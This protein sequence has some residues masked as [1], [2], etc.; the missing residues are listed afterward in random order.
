MKKIITFLLC[1]NIVLSAAAC[2][3]ADRPDNID[4]SSQPGVSETVPTESE[5]ENEIYYEIEKF[6]DTT[7]KYYVY[8]EDGL[9]LYKKT[10]RQS[11]VR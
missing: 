10:V 5:P 1:Y 9:L 2:T 4:N 8:G 11:T 3:K 6:D 7:S